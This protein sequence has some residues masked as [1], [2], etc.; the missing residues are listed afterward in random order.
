MTFATNF[1]SSSPIVNQD[2]NNYVDNKAGQGDSIMSQG[3]SVLYKFM[4]LFSDLAQGKYDQMSA[5]ADRARDSQQAANQVDSIIAQLKDAGSTGSLPKEVIDYLRSHNISVTVQNDGK[6]TSGSIDDYLKSIGCKFDD[7]G[8]ATGLNKGQLD[9]IKG[10]LETDS[11]RCSDFVTQ[12][13][14]QI[15]KTMQSYNVCVSL[16][17]SMQSL[18]AEMNK[19]IAQNIR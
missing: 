15:Q 19:S 8:N 6:N 16:I 17:N 2:Y 14:L 13:Q 9:V 1:A 12:A 3:I 4:T 10:A 11:G 7:Q 18:L 5:K